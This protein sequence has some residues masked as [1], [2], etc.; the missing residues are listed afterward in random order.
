MPGPFRLVLLLCLLLSAGEVAAQTL[1]PAGWREKW[2]L[3]NADTLKIDSLSLVPGSLMVA[4][5]DTSGY[6]VDAFGSKLVWK[7]RPAQD[8]IRVRYRVFPFSFTAPYARKPIGLIENNILITP[9]YYSASEAAKQKQEF[10]DFGSVD[11]SGS[12]GRALSFGNSQDVVLNSQFNLQ[13]DGDLGDSIR[14]TGAITDNTIPFQPEGN[15]QQLQEFDRVFIQLRRK[16]AS[17]MVGDHDIR[18]PAGYFMQ[19][20][21]R[22]QGAFVSTSTPTGKGG[23]NRIAVGASLAKGKFVRNVL[24]ALEGNQG[25]YKLTGPN[26]EQFFVVLAGTERVYIDGQVQSRGENQ[27]Y[28][29]DYNTAEITFMPRRLIT[30]DLR[31]VVEFEFSDRNYLNSLLYLSDEWQINSKWQ[32]RFNAYSNQDA[33]NQ[34]VMLSL[35]SSQKAFLAGI[36]DS[37]Q[38]ALYPSAR[39]QDT[40]SNNLILYRKTDT[41]VNGTLYSGIYVF[42]TDPDSARYSLAFT[43]VGQGRGNYRQALSSANGRVY[44]WL[45]P[46]NGLPQ[47]DYEPVTILVTPKKQQLFTLGTTFRPDSNRTFQ[48]EAALSD[49][50]PNLFSKI[51]NQTHRGVAT[52]LSYEESRRLGKNDKRRISSALYYEYVQDRFRPLERFRQVEFVRDWNI[53]LNEQAQTEHLGGVK[54]GL[55]QKDLGEVE[56]RIGTYTRGSNFAG[57]QQVFALGGQKGGWRVL[58][59]GDWVTQRSNLSRS[60]FLRPY[61]ELERTFRKLAGITIGSRFLMDHNVLRDAQTDTLLRSAFSF[62]AL[63]LYLRNGAAGKLPF[64][65]EY[66][67]RHDRAAKDNRMMPGTVGHTVAVNAGVNKGPAHDLKITAAY[68][69]LQVIDSTLTAFKPD[70][71]LLGRAEYQFNW[72]SGLLTG[73]ILYEMGAGQELKREFTY[74][75]VPAG[76]GQYVWRDYNGDNLRQL[77]EFELAIFPDERLFI[78]VFTP[79]NQYVKAKYSVYNQSVSLSPRSLF[80]RGELKG[81]RKVLGLFHLQSAVQLNNR[82]LGQPGLEQYNPFIRRFEDS[83]LINNSSS[84]MNTVF[85]NRFSNVW[86]LDYIQT[87]NGGKTLL[88]YGVDSRRNTEHQFRGRTNLNP[89]FTLTAALRRGK[90]S[91][92]SPFL[93]ARTYLVRYTAAETGF[94]WL[95]LRNQFRVQSGYR[96]DIRNN[97]ARYGGEKAV[98]HSIQTDLRY[99]LPGSGTVNVRATYSS[100]SFNGQANSTIG[101][102]ML[103]GLQNGRNWLWGAQFERRLSRNVE[104]SLEYEG[105]RPGGGGVIHTGRASVRA[106]F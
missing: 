50:D 93:E 1:L 31:I 33:R 8:S 103:D 37:I 27:D 68:R 28:I 2:V 106:V 76:Q 43:S 84:V 61:A 80:G 73:N 87:L 25:P 88:N 67:L 69:Q 29:I 99:N 14:L 101:Y 78:R 62:D 17:L 85:L 104:M 11:Y 53:P 4:G 83:L 56:Y 48:V 3:S 46:V 90:K 10:V 105:R 65:A 63:T 47:G 55:Q 23:E 51:G 72:W 36:G 102:T 40:F 57:L 45:E 92:V 81:W 6:S 32:V 96:Y 71:T 70:E 86:G 98:S 82:F 21:K 34:P 7:K 52:R 16:R 66:T 35:D 18:K 59:R 19:F 75:Q 58:A 94:T 60:S 38:L 54:L 89:K 97:E 30:K 22:V 5:I 77:N 74:V 41:T 26:G 91:F 79:T 24:T 95:L 20:Y 100:I 9:Y 12:F 15:T 49:F 13:L 44:E 42:S 64:Q 39:Y